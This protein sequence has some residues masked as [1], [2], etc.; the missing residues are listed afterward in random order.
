M[1]D[2]KKITELKITQY[3]LSTIGLLIIAYQILAFFV[4]GEHVIAS[5]TLQIQHSEYWMY[6]GG[7]NCFSGAAIHMFYEYK[8]IN[9]TST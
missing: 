9:R 8:N 3:A 6:F 4:E 5:H 7:L 1:K 2:D